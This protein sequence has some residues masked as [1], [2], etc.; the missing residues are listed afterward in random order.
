MWKVDVEK[1]PIKISI[2]PTKQMAITICTVYKKI[3]KSEIKY[4]STIKY[5]Y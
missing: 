3:E 4:L 5:N 1:E 2:V